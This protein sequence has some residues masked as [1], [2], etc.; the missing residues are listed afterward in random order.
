ME[1][2][3]CGD[4]GSGK[5]TLITALIKKF[6]KDFQTGYLK[7]TSHSFEMDIKGKD[8]WKAKEAGGHRVGIC[9]PNKAAFLWKDSQD[10]DL[11]KENFIDCDILLVE[12]F[13]ELPLS[14]ILIWTG[15]TKDHAFLHRHDFHDNLLAIVGTDHPPSCSLPFFHRD[16]IES[17][18]DFIKK[19]WQK[20]IS[21][22]PLYGL[23]LAG[24]RSK[25]M[26]SDKVG[27]SYRGISQAEY[28]FNLLQEH[29]Q[30]TYLSRSSLQEGFS[31]FP[32]IEDCYQGLGPIGGILSAF[33][34]HPHAAW[35]VQACDMP[36][37]NQ[38]AL[39]QLLEERNPFRLAT[40]FFNSKKKW[41]EPLLAIYEKKAA[42]KLGTYLA[43]GI[44][45]PK[46]ILSHSPIQ[47]VRPND[48][49]ILDNINTLDEYRNA[50]AKIQETLR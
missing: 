10:K 3:F 9:S 22:T 26:G 31:H 30:Q 32:V 27:L 12:G 39:I 48:S 29:C 1:I 13:K 40:C 4:S 17:I 5:T 18:G 49:T 21:S 37:V 8:T 15:S 50:H 6:S 14:K 25:R 16:D 24:G 45:C 44:K 19:I 2:S 20:K 23:I 35:L 7:H 42:Y 33:H 28:Y 43:R 46:K 41:P 38:E 47:C 34:R 36:F 11:L